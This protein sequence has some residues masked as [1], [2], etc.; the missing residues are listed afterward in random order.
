MTV[1]IMKTRASRTVLDVLLLGGVF[2][3][4]VAPPG[5]ALADVARLRN[6]SSLQISGFVIEDT[7]VV[8]Q[9]KGGGQ[10]ALP[11]S[12]ILEI[13]RQPKVTNNRKTNGTTRRSETRNRDVE[14][15]DAAEAGAPGGGV[16]SPGPVNL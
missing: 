3:A 7:W 6:G 11:Q 12:Q 16:I 15:R 9:L 4:L 5:T 2:F 1:K 8:L 13:V 10:I 14:E